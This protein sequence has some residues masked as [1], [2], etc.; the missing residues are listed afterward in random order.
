MNAIIK[1]Y[2][3]TLG[4]C[5]IIVALNPVYVSAAST[6]W[7]V[8]D[9][10]PADFSNI[11]DAINAASSGDTVQVAAGIYNENIT[12]KSGVIVRGAGAD[13][14]IIDSGGRRVSV[15]TA[16][17]VDS[18]AKLDGFTLTGGRGP[19]SYGG[20]GIQCRYSSPV[21][22][23]CIIR[24]NSSDQGGGISLWFNCNP[25]IVNCIIAGN[26]AAYG[27]GMQ[28]REGCSPLIINCTI[29][30][31]SASYWGAGIRIR[32]SCSPT[33]INCIIASNAA[34]YGGG[35]IEWNSASPYIDYN[36][37][38][39]NLPDDYY[40]YS[41]GVNDISVEPMFANPE[42]GD[43]H[44]QSTSLCIDVG[45]NDAPVIP[46]IDFEGD[47]R[48]V[49]GDGNSTAV[50]DM[51]ADEFIPVVT[52]PGPGEMEVGGEIYPAGKVTL[53]IPWMALVVI[54]I[55]VIT[56]LVWRRA[57]S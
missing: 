35:G 41:P 21:I 40:P 1:R 52:P 19:V 20:G 46:S 31:N 7:T 25:T 23:N 32:Y 48:L 10:G 57:H 38:W 50:V 3:L 8:D 51:G 36:D 54:F 2:L 47:P 42:I 55:A 22:S 13:I 5:F 39:G 45:R 27:G 4:L 12:L 24:N 18:T 34:V 9:D 37:V 11:Q 6:T 17:Y 43:Y 29:V 14:T 44:L 16:V 26:S 28:V 53:F 30:N 56:V 33:I 49:D 15:V